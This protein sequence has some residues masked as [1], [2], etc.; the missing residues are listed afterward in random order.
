MNLLILTQYFPPEVG[1]PQNRL[2]DLA[3]RL[4]T[5][6]VNVTVLTAMPNYPQMKIY[7][8]YQGKKYVYEEIQGIPVH[9]ASIY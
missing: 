4:K 1:A 3:F 9:R 8:G 5:L 7:E 6:G 2:F